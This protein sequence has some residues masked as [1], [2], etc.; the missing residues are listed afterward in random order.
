MIHL[1]DVKYSRYGT[2]ATVCPNEGELVSLPQS[3]IKHKE[4]GAM[5]VHTSGRYLVCGVCG[6]QT[7]VA[8]I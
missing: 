7:P 3:K 6:A 2:E 1:L 8:G 5:Q 4:H